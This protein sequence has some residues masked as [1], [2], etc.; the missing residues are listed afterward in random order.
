MGRTQL[1]AQCVHVVKGLGRETD[2]VP[3]CNVK[4]KNARI[5]T[6]SPY[7]CRDVVHNFTV[8][9]SR[10]IMIDLLAKRRTGL[11]AGRHLAGWG[12]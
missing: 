11:G 8:R 6:S 10:G 12:W 5:Y 7:T 3:A 4:F 2:H 9:H 1:A